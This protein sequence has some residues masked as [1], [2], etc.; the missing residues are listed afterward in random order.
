MAFD[1]VDEDMS[2]NLDLGELSTVLRSV[3]KEMRLN[4]PADNDIIAVLA[5]L[6]QDNDSQ[7][8]KDEFEYL[9]IKVLEKMAE[10]ELEIEQVVN[11]GLSQQQ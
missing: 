6:D 11:R 4:P 8:S 3:A 7:V 5:E 1:A 2:G 9:I 10:S